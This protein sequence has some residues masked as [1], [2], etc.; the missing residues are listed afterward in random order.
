MVFLAY[1]LVTG[2][3]GVQPASK[4]IAAPTLEV[5]SQSQ[6]QCA[7]VLRVLHVNLQLPQHALGSCKLEGVALDLQVW[8]VSQPTPG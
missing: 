5:N 4:L 3:T 1:G 6:W 8:A 7:T 2:S